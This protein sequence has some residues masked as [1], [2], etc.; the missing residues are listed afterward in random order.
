MLIKVKWI[1]KSNLKAT[2]SIFNDKQISYLLIKYIKI[3]WNAGML[4]S[5]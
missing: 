3:E 4:N 5:V 1:K 2:K